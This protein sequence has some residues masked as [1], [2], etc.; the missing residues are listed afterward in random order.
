M[1]KKLDSSRGVIPLAGELEQINSYI[2]IEKGR[3]GELIQVN[4]D[5]EPGCENWPIPS[6]IIQPLVKNAIKHWI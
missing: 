1:R 6:L 4:I 3:F 5:V 2:A